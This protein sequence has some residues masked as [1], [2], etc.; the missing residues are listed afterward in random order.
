MAVCSAVVAGCA[1]LTSLNDEALKLKLIGTRGEQQLMDAK[2]AL[3]AHDYERAGV[4]YRQLL[5]PPTM[6]DRPDEIL[7]AREGLCIAL[8]H[9]DLCVAAAHS[10]ATFQ[11]STTPEHPTLREVWPLIAERCA[12]A[13]DQAVAAHELDAAENML[14]P[15]GFVPNAYLP[16]A[17]RV[18]WQNSI[19]KARQA[20]HAAVRSRREKELGASIQEYTQYRVVTPYELYQQPFATNEG[21]VALSPRDMPQMYGGRFVQMVHCDGSMG[22]V[23]GLRFDRMLSEDQALYDINIYTVGDGASDVARVS[24]LLVVLGKPASSGT[25][26]MMGPLSYQYFWL[27]E[28]LGTTEGRNALGAPMSIPT[29]RF[30]GYSE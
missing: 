6:I 1:A 3:A 16:Q 9:G 20:D 7:A 23:C 25:V 30:S 28:R 29:V 27:V 13:I 10:C 12:R 11:K 2:V 15:I 17:R 18:E 4:L 8:A 21:L 24:Q 22:S 14:A 26:N 5:G 19:A